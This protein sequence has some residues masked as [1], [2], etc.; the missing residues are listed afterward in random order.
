[1]AMAVL[2]QNQAVT[3]HL[4]GWP[5]GFE[6]LRFLQGR[7]GQTFPVK[8]QVV[9]ILGFGAIRSNKFTPLS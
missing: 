4:N 6:R 7:A 5:L 8:D 1:M 2:S 3:L 9:N